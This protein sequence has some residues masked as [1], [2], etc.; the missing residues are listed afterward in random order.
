M[1]TE[2][3]ADGLLASAQVFV[4]EVRGWLRKRGLLPE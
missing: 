1:V 2:T 3:E 4:S